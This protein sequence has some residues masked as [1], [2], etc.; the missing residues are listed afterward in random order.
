MVA[1]IAFG[2]GIDKPDVRFVAHLDL[3]KSL[4]AY[5]QETGRA[6]R[7]GLPADAWMAYGLGD[8]V[9]A[10]AASSRTRRPRST[11]SAVEQ[12]KLNALL[13]FCETTEC[14][15]QVML[16]Y[17]GEEHARPCGNCD[18]CLEPGRDLGRHRGRPKALSCIFRTGQ[19]F[20]ADYLIDVLL[21]KDD[22]RIRRFGHDRVSH[23]R[24]RPGT[25]R[26]RNGSRSTGNWWP[27]AWW[28]STWRATGPPAHRAEP[29][30]PAR[31]ARGP[32]APRPHPGPP[33][34]GRAAE[35]PGTPGAGAAQVR[36]RGRPGGDRPSGSACA[37]CAGTGPGAERAALRHLQRRHPAG[38]GPVP[39]ARP[40]RDQPDQRRRR[41]QAG[42][43]WRGLPGRTG[44][45]CRRARPPGQLPPLPEPPLRAAAPRRPC[46]RT[47]RGGGPERHRP[48]HPGPAAHRP[49]ARRDRRAPDL[50]ISTIYTH[51]SRCI[52]EGE[53]SLAEIVTL[54]DDELQAIEYAFNQLT[55]DSPLTLKPVYDAFQ[56]KY[57]YGL[58]RCVRA[59]I[60]SGNY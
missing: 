4:E 56:G 1:T 60:E 10:A 9:T 16:N 12:H 19:R 20:G 36:F 49:H 43:L 6:G 7:D 35:D 44:R 37:P 5:Y 39:T 52:E 58:L 47:P 55:A 48:R 59:A 17:F 40:G 53:L 3:P 14:R 15:R 42:A 2:M 33:A 46:R 18:T 31:R 57:D 22:E 26:R 11:S 8:V 29:P 50:K 41:G 38:A 23:L 51:L 24:H 27:P 45:P 34:G 30:G 54:T 28:R 21:G 25:E 13:G 32:A